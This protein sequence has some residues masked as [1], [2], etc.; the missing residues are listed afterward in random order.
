M[1]HS[2]GTRS[3]APTEESP[4]VPPVT[5]HRR[6][7]AQPTARTVPATR[8]TTPVPIGIHF[9][10]GS[11]DRVCR[12]VSDIL[13]Y[14]NRGES[15][16][17]E[18]INKIHS[19]P[20]R[21]RKSLDRQGLLGGHVGVNLETLI[22]AFLET[23]KGMSQDTQNTYTRQFNFLLEHFGK[24]RKISSID[25]ASCLRFKADKLSFYS[26]A[27]LCMA[28][29]RYRSLFT[30]AVDSFWLE[31]NPFN[32]IKGGKENNDK[33]QVYIPRETILNVIHHCNNTRDKLLLALARFGGLRIPSEIKHMRYSDFTDKTIRIHPDTK[34]GAREIPLFRDIQ[35]FYNALVSEQGR[36]FNPS[37]L[38]FPELGDFHR[39]I[40][41]AIERSG[42]ERWQ[43]KF[44]NLRSSCT[45]DLES[46]GLSEKTL[47]CIFGNSAAIRKKHYVQFLKDKEFSRLLQADSQSHEKSSPLLLLQSLIKTLSISDIEKHKI[48]LLLE[49]LFN[50]F[51]AEKQAA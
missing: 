24:E 47:D 42:E 32:T 21:L 44:I 27:S 43:K 29:R 22:T 14:R 12:I 15:L 49:T 46:Q 19:L 3:G 30:F 34:T 26:P 25:T 31:R 16:S 1:G 41:R 11:A 48:F 6:I 38:I 4:Q 39:R 7:P 8:I 36:E 20:E 51:D 2:S 5:Q 9:T 33:R 13:A 18:L 10:S 37:D 28:L 45:T 17:G 40:D 23:K 50:S 35:S